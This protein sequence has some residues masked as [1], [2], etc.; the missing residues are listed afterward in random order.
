ME[1]TLHLIAE[2]QQSLD[3]LRANT[4]LTRQERVSMM[5]AERRRLQVPFRRAHVIIIRFHMMLLLVSCGLTLVPLCLPSYPD[6]LF[7]VALPCRSWRWRCW[8]WRN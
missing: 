8:R 1:D 3:E 2:V 7:A 5:E 6:C 4:A